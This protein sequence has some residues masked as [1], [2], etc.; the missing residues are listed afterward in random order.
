[1][2]VPQPTSEPPRSGAPKAP[3]RNAPPEKAAP[4]SRHRR[5]ALITIAS[6]IGTAI[7]GAAATALITPERVDQLF[8]ALGSAVAS[9]TASA[10][11][12]VEYKPVT[13][14]DRAVS[15]EVP[16]DWIVIDTSYDVAAGGIVEPGASLLAGDAVGDGSDWGESAVYVGASTATASRYELPASTAEERTAILGALA[17]EVDW[18]IDHCLRTD[19][20]LPLPTGFA[21]ISTSWDD[22]AQT[23]GMRL[24]EIYASSADGA[25]FL[26]AQIFL[27]PGADASI[28]RHVIETLTITRSE[29]PGPAGGET[30][31][32]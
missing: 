12:P 23:D 4:P 24:W 3:A 17:D 8:G 13:G 26:L 20:A 32:P 21:G 15:L 1:M 28:A 7:A 31:M 27:P 5:A 22:C 25:V 10:T 16:V 2:P 19:D 29:I 18:S 30:V 11:D 9:Q 6:V 14:V